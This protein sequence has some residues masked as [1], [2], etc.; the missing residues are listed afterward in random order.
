ME[1]VPDRG[2]FWSQGQEP[3]ESSSLPGGWLQGQARLGAAG[4][5]PS[6][7][8]KGFPPRRAVRGEMLNTCENS[9]G[10]VSAYP[11]EVDADVAK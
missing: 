3:P 5:L 6:P 8:I 11:A 2:P 1:G 7:R 10:I 9:R 4:S